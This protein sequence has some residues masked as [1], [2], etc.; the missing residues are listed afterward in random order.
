MQVNTQA[1]PAPGDQLPTPCTITASTA[2]YPALYPA[3]HAE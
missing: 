2:L 1:C 3:P